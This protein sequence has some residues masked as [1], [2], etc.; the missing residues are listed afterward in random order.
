[1]DKNFIQLVPQLG[2]VSFVKDNGGGYT[3]W[4][5]DKK[6]VVAEGETKEE[7]IENLFHVNEVFNQIKKTA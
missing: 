6:G 7:A 1:M 5:T 4:L 3:V 2:M